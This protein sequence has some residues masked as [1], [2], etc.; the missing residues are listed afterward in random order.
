[1]KKLFGSIL[2]AGVALIGMLPLY[3]ATDAIKIV[4]SHPNSRDFGRKGAKVSN[5]I[6]E[7]ASDLKA[8]KVA[9][10]ITLDN[11]KNTEVVYV[12]DNTSDLQAKKSDIVSK[13]K[14]IAKNLESSN[15]GYVK[16][17]VV[18]SDNEDTN[19]TAELTNTGIE[20][21]FD[22][23]S[24]AEV[25]SSVQLSSLVETAQGLFTTSS[26]SVKV[27]VIFTK[28][29]GEAKSKIEALNAA[30]I[31]AVVYTVDQESSLTTNEDGSVTVVQIATS[32][33]EIVSTLTKFW[34]TS[35]QNTTGTVTFDPYIYNNFD[36]SDVTSNIG[37]ATYDESTHEITWTPGTVNRNKVAKL[38]YTLVLK[39]SFDQ[40]IIDKVEMRTNRQ[41]K[42]SANIEAD[43]Q[44]TGTYPENPN[45][46]EP[47]S[48]VIMISG[49]PTNPENPDT[50]ITN[51]V[52]FGSIIIALGAVTLVLLS[53]KN[54]FNRL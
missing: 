48:P 40:D 6:N 43:G 10:E 11:A 54:A 17:A 46:E 28:S 51:Y 50:G 53:K 3:A 49:I 20:V 4:S 29:V 47:C 36:I 38:T 41:L 35:I 15:D 42:L 22:N 5:V 14:D 16:Q 1:M 37:T 18:Y 33:D 39:E 32:F 13:V 31:K 34:T 45:D 25:S 7:S 26:D 9:I 12:F 44:A 2:I 8:G 52:V 24:S 30:G 21:E 27:M 23:V 19:N